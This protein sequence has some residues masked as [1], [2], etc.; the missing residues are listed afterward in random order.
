MDGDII[1]PDVE[2]ARNK[3]C[4]NGFNESPGSKTITDKETK[5]EVR[6]PSRWNEGRSGAA[7]TDSLKN[8]A[9]SFICTRV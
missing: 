5:V 1:V 2:V 6:L 4:M 7:D 3:V 8:S 9:S